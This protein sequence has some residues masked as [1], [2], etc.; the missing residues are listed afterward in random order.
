MH[1][2]QHTTIRRPLAALFPRQ[3]SH[4]IPCTAD[5]I[6]AAITEIAVKQNT[7]FVSIAALAVVLGLDITSRADCHWLTTELG[8]LDTGGKVLLNSLERPQDLL[9]SFQP[10]HVR[11]AAGIPCHEVCVPTASTLSAELRLVEAHQDAQ[12]EGWMPAPDA[13]TANPHVA[14]RRVTTLL[15]DAAQTLNRVLHVERKNTANA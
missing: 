13:S 3:A 6:L 1:P 15:Q 12:R 5:D 2:T 10:W 11:N 14:R 4:G 7:Q 9:P 8:N